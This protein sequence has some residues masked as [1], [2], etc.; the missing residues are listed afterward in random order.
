MSLG[1]SQFIP[2]AEV[3]STRPELLRVGGALV[4]G[5]L[6][7]VL[8]LRRRLGLWLFLAAGCQVVYR[9][10]GVLPYFA[11]DLLVFLFTVLVVRWTPLSKSY[12]RWNL[13]CVAM[14]V[15]SIVALAGRSMGWDS[16]YTYIAGVRLPLF[17]LDMFHL[18]VLVT[19]LWEVGSSR[20]ELPRFYHYAVWRCIPI[21]IV[22]L[23][24]SDFQNQLEGLASKAPVREYPLGR[25]AAL[26]G[27]AVIQVYSG[28]LCIEARRVL[29]P[30]GYTVPLW[31]KLLVIFFLG[32]WSFYLTFAGLSN[33]FIVVG[34]LW[35]LRVPVNYRNPFAAHNISEFWS[36][37]NITLTFVLRDYLF[38]NRWGLRRPNIYANTF[39][40]F[41]VMGVW[42]ALNFYWVVFGLLHGCGFCIYLWFR[43]FQQ[44]RGW[45]LPQG[46]IYSLLGTAVT[47][48]FVCSCWIVPSQISKFLGFI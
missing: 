28:W 23:R 35:S 11:T 38:F 40:V 34:L 22:I 14:V 4:V 41:L 21:D 46:R 47:Y 2:T 25:A 42:H 13:C 18:V 12:I 24:Y 15:L 44:A 33:M 48:I 31:G 39:I 5:C 9:Q 8:P 26:A 10:E 17:Q 36:R 16:Y 45:S 20:V 1:L 7:F 29:F 43:Q 30:E 6:L 19:Y 37:W 27:L 3:F 32:P